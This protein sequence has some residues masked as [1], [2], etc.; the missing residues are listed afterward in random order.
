MGCPVRYNIPRHYD[1]QVIPLTTTLAGEAANVCWLPLSL[2]AP[3][4]G[5]SEAAAQAEGGK[6]K[7]SSK[8]KWKPKKKDE[9]DKEED[10]YRCDCTLCDNPSQQ[11]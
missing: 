1:S 4:A 6:K 5:F 7:S 8:P 11:A 9:E 10:L 3:H 2:P